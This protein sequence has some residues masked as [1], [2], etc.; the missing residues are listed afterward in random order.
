MSND[1][2]KVARKA[3][4]IWEAEGR[5]HGKDQDHWHRASAEVAAEAAPKPASR[6]TAVKPAAAKAATSKTRARAPAK[7]TPAKK[8]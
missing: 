1:D 7:K 3:Y 4:E 6:K 2:P 5:P 8:A